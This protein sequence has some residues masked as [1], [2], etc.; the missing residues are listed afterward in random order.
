M[1]KVFQHHVVKYDDTYYVQS[2]EVGDRY[3]VLTTSKKEA[4][5]YYLRG[6]A[7][8]VADKFNGHVETIYQEK[9][10]RVPSGET[11]FRKRC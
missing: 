10:S 11:D 1:E 6:I 3:P 2:Y 5:P 7:S 9:E 8:L 4:K